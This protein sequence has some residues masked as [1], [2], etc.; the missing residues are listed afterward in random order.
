M[1]ASRASLL[2]LASLLG[3]MAFS[4]AC[5]NLYPIRLSIELAATP[6]NMAQV[7]RSPSGNW[8]EQNSQQKQIALA[9]EELDFQIPI[10]QVGTGVRFDPGTF[11]GEYRIL[12]VRWQRGMMTRQ[13]KPEMIGNLREGVQQL[14]VDGAAVK[15]YSPDSDAQVFLP[16]PGEPWRLLA[17][18]P[19]GV[20]AAVF[21]YLLRRAW[22][23]SISPTAVASAYV[24]LVASVYVLVAF[25]YMSN[26]PLLDDWRYIVPGPLLLVGNE[27][28][29]MT[30]ITNDTY[31]LTGQLLDFVALKLTNV[32]F[33]SVRWMG[34]GILLIYLVAMRRTLLAAGGTTL[35]AAV[36]IALIAGVLGTNGYWGAT[37]L[38][39]HQFIPLTVTAMLL[40]YVGGR[41]DR[42]IGL[43]GSLLVIVPLCAAAGLAYISGGLM[44]ACVGAGLL[45]A[46]ADRWQRLRDSQVRTAWLI[47]LLG[48]AFLLLQIWLVST[49]QGSLVKHNHAVG[50]VY[51]NDPRFYYFVT[52]LFGRAAGYTGTNIVIDSALMLLALF[53]AM[54]LAAERLWFGLIRGQ[55]AERPLL[56]ALPLCAAAAALTYAAAVAF[57]RAGFHDVIYPQPSITGAAKVRF[58][59]CTIAALLP[60]MWLGWVEL[61]RRS[62]RRGQ[63]LVATAA[64]TAVALLLILP[65]TLS[66]WRVADELETVREQLAEGAY[67]AAAAMD[68]PS[69]PA[70]ICTGLSGIAADLR[71]HLDVM[72]GL[73]SHV[74]RTIRSHALPPA[75]APAA[76]TP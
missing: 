70:V 61:V 26:L 73:D 50:S 46:Q 1:S 8:N 60:L 75:P 18:W 31:F 23:N 28:G 53:P 19:I 25:T 48:A 27:Y 52:A 51:P 34:I 43:G 17:L 10:G 6:G 24:G 72:K 71:P 63:R 62:T 12:A 7:F 68:A 66:S 13:L 76:T 44:I 37:S 56:T 4:F 20:V 21:L 15:L 38:A 32:N 11:G 67:C 22:R 40:A 42:E 69:R 58:H 45:L 49:Q 16:A 30:L 36:G 35:G 57:G 64:A 59:F 5:L 14:V 74:H 2:F 54:L 65:K 9:V 29:W 55:S 47:T 39:Y 41:G 3:F 33:L